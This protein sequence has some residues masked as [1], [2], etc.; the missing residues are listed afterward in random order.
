MRLK[1]REYPTN[2]VQLNMIDN[3]QRYS[4]VNSFLDG[5]LA[6]PACWMESEVSAWL[7]SNVRDLCSDATI[8]S[9]GNLFE[10]GLDRLVL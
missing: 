5:E 1:P 2:Y 6:A 3:Y 4:D 8:T 7:L 9:N 10:Q